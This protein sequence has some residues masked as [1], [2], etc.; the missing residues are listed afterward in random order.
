MNQSVPVELMVMMSVL[1]LNT[2]ISKTD[3]SSIRYSNEKQLC[4]ATLY[5]IVRSCC[6]FNAMSSLERLGIKTKGKNITRSENQDF[7]KEIT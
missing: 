1:P 3:A 6:A 5:G 2:L 7:A 4:L